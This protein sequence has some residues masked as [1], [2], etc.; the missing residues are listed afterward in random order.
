MEV[1]RESGSSPEERADPDEILSWDYARRTGADSWRILTAPT[2]WGAREWLMAGGVGAAVG[3]TML[4]DHEIRSL[5]RRNRSETTEDAAEVLKYFG[6]VV[7][8][9]VIGA[10]YVG[11]QMTGNRTAKAIAADGLEAS[12]ISN[13]LFVVPLKFLLGRERPEDDRGAQ[14]YDPF[15]LGSLPSFHATEAFAVAS[16]VAEHLDHP[17]ASILAY[18]LASS[19]GLSRIHDDRHWASDIVLSAAIGTAVGKAVTF[20][21]RERRPS[22][23]SLVPLAKPDTWGAAL[24]YQY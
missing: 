6:H 12:L 17:L 9:A 16:V 3:G 13:L 11:G 1:R 19:V 22:G 18:G 5:V 14:D 23:V 7:P 10:S 20:L 8:A 21:N 24:L 2:R 4:L 15:H